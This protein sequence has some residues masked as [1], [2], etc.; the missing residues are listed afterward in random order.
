VRGKWVLENVIGSP[1]PAPPPD[2]PTLDE[3][4]PE[5]KMTFRQKLEAH[6]ANPACAGC[7][8]VMDPIGFALENFDATGA[9]RDYEK[10]VGSTP[11]NASGKLAD[12]TLVTGAVELRRSIMTRPETFVSTVVEKLMTYALGRGLGGRDIPVVREIVRDVAD[13]DYRFSSVVLAIVTS[14]PFRMRKAPVDGVV[15]NVER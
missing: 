14:E 12:G 3:I 1:P 5:G 8:A 6:R 11:I 15:A 13:D 7:H 9:W 10:G 4:D 2:V